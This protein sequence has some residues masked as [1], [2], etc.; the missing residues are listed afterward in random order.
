MLTDENP[1]F[2]HCEK[3]G[4][5]SV[6]ENCSIRYYKLKNQFTDIGI[7]MNEATGKL[8]VKG[9]FGMF[10]NGHNINTSFADLSNAINYA[11]DKINVDLFPAIVEE[12]D[13]SATLSTAINTKLIIQNHLSLP[14]HFTLLQPHGK[15][16]IKEGLEKV[17]IYDAGRRIKQIY[18]KAIREK[19]YTSSGIDPTMNFLRFEKKILNPQAYF[20]SII[21][22]NELLRP[23]FILQCNNDLMDTYNNII[24]AGSL[25][26]PKNKKYLTAA[27][28]PLIVAK[29][30][31]AV[32]GFDFADLIKKR[33]SAIDE[34]ILTKDD[35][36]ARKRQIKANLNKI[37]GKVVS[38]YDISYQLAESLKISSREIA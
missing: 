30:L 29:E 17:K 38:E 18:S 34:S 13:H 14:G 27:T 24:K 36:K 31:E 20:K 9:N 3:P 28:L 19:I 23:E 22:V 10:W 5:F 32:Y 16:F 15:Y 4:F 1:D 8:N 25:Q 2:S 37:T 6:G 33:I 12:L 21:T 26:I 7:S 11:S 35:K